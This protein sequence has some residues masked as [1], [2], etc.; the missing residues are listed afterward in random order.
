MTDLDQERADLNNLVRTAHEAIKD[1]TAI[2]RR[3]DDK[4]ATAEKIADDMLVTMKQMEQIIDNM[5]AQTIEEKFA[6]ATERNI[7]A[8]DQAWLDAVEV[9]KRK[10]FDRF[11]TLF[12]QIVPKGYG[13]S[14]YPSLSDEITG[15]S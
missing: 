7:E 11:D 8:Y 2:E 13:I 3:I 6:A 14:R 10:I 1:L 15:G 12:A 5:V 9:A 4:I